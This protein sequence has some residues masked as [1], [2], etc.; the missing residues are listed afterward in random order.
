MK[1]KC[2]EILPAGNLD[3][4][5]KTWNEF[6]EEF[7]LIKEEYPDHTQVDQGIQ[8]EIRERE[9]HIFSDS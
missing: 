5:I 1:Y 6:W 9:L 8:G 3:F 4:E 7:P 2:D